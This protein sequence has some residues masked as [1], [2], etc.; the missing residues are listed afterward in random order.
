[1]EKRDI[2]KPSPAKAKNS[3]SPAS[4]PPAIKFVEEAELNDNTPTPTQEDDVVEES[5]DRHNDAQLVDSAIAKP[6][7]QNVIQTEEEEEEEKGADTT[8]S[9]IETQAID[10][11]ELSAQLRTIEDGDLSAQLRQIDDSELSA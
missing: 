1:M 3:A 7:V 4:K 2:K 8:Y 5:K 6:E 11:S 10:D 9:M